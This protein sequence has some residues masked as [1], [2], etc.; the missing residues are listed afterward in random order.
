M[1]Y[2]R[3]SRLNPEVL[4]NAGKVYLECLGNDRT[5]S[6]NGEEVLAVLPTDEKSSFSLTFVPDKSL[7]CHSE[8]AKLKITPKN[9]TFILNEVLGC[10]T[11]E[12]V[13]HDGDV[14]KLEDMGLY[15]IPLNQISH[16]K[17]TSKDGYDLEMI[18]GQNEE[19][20]PAIQVSKRKP[21]Y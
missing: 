1:P 6:V 19:G 10:R 9:G 14:S 18:L 5:F 7:N 21:R 17:T 11:V 16:I 4:I 3:L 13:R 12:V 8:P 20:K 2:E 15:E